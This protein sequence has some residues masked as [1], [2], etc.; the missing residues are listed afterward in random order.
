MEL[1]TENSEADL[2]RQRAAAEVRW[3]LREMTANLLCV[4]QGVGKPHEIVQQVPALLE[5]LVNYRDVVGVLPPPEDLAS[6][7]AVDRDPELLEQVK[8]RE[9]TRFYA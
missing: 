7:L 4:V 3:A 6:F 8:D 9:L 1:A 2:A 5:T